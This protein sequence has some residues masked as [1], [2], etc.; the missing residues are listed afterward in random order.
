MTSTTDIAT[1]FAAAIAVFA[2]IVGPPKGNDL[3]N[4]RK[5]LLQI[6]LSIS[7]AG[8]K[9][10]KV[11]GLILIDSLYV[12]TPGITELFRDDKDFLDEYDPKIK[13]DTEAWEQRKFVTFW[14]SCLVN[15][16]RI[17]ATT[18][19][20]RQLLLHAFDEVYYVTLR[21]KNTF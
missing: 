5:V 7:L 18:H 20:C 14:T 4:I 21:S 11:T 15:Q 1:K 12:T 2:P 8:S 3:R 10:G 6:C 17:T 16:F 9:S 19:S 13:K